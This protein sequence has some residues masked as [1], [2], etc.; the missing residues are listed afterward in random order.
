MTRPD[1]DPLPELIDSDVAARVEA[2]KAVMARDQLEV[3]LVTKPV[4]VR[5]L[6][7]FT[8]SNGALLVRPGELHLV[9]DGR[10][11]EQAHQQLAAA[12]VDAEIVITPTGLVEFV[13][14]RVAGAASL[15]LESD[16]LVWSEVQRYQTTIEST[17][18]VPTSGLI[19]TLRQIK[20]RGERSRLE[21][22]SGIADRSLIQTLPLLGERPTEREFANALD[23]RMRINGADDVSFDTIVAS[24]PNAAL[25]HHRP[26]SRFVESE[27]LVVID[28]GAKVDGYGSDMT[29]TFVAG[30]RPTDEQQRLYDAVA[31]AQAAGVAAVRA[32]VKQR[33]IHTTCWNVLA[34]H[35]LSE[36]FIH[37]TGH[38]LG[39]EI[40]EEPIMSAR[41]VGIL[42]AGLIVTVEPGAY[43]PGFGGVRVEDTVV[44][45]DTGCVPITHCPKG[46]D[47]GAVAR[48][49]PS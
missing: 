4:N 2:L 37:G 25:P 40:H 34:E 47:P 38:G 17:E 22:A 48:E 30:G 12:G 27:D 16:H 33:K 24:G 11:E 35:D 20:D 29:R 7:G 23:H 14:D 6:T 28:F 46:L 39:L 42:R 45:T 15:G 49:F 10:Y 41:S 19:E 36:A 18:L 31:A 9:T 3:L 43:L 13:A 32:G 26:G 1:V 21:R 8:G 5:W 44:V